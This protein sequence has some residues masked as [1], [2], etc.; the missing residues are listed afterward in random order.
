LNE[1]E[2]GEVLW[3]KDFI[4]RKNGAFDLTSKRA[5]N[6]RKNKDSLGRL[7]AF[8]EHWRNKQR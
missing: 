7:E 5:A 2:R 3:G 1:A 8:R 6:R 4:Q